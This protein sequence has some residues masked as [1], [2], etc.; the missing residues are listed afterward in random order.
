MSNLASFIAAADEDVTNNRPRLH[1]YICIYF[2]QKRMSD[3]VQLGL[4]YTYTRERWCVYIYACICVMYMS[5]EC[6][7]WLL[8]YV[9]VTG[10]VS[11][12]FLI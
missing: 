3:K 2:A 9:C 6:R 5:K 8:V 10:V 7:G 11:R 4:W 12:V 1:G